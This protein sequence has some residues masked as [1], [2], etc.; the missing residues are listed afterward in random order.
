[1]SAQNATEAVEI[2]VTMLDYKRFLGNCYDK[3]EISL[4]F[5]SP[6]IWDSRIPGTSDRTSVEA[7][8]FHTTTQSH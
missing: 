3:N 1:M 5:A 4:N 7:L 2:L 8:Q 6:Q